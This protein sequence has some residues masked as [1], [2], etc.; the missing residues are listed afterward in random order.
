MSSEKPDLLGRSTFRSPEDETIF[1]RA[2]GDCICKQ[3]GKKY[4]DHPMAR[5]KEWLSWDGQPFLH[6]LCNGRLV[7]L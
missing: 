2:G 3:C 4:Y 6:R 7:K 5:E 1:E